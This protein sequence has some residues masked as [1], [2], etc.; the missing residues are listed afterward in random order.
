MERRG[1]GF[2][3]YSDIERHDWIPSMLNSPIAAKFS[4]SAPPVWSASRDY[5]RPLLHVL[6]WG[7]NRD[8]KIYRYKNLFNNPGALYRWAGSCGG[9]V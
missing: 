5:D 2:R 4:L 6:G 1:E 8:Y 7:I 3:G 9:I